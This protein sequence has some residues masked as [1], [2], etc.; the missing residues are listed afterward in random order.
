LKNTT[1]KIGRQYLDTP[2]AFTEKWNV[3][4]NSFD[5]IVVEN[6]DIRNVTLVGTYIGKG[7]GAF[8]RVTNGERFSDYGL[9]GG[10]YA[11][12]ALTNFG[13][14]VNVWYYNVKSD[15]NP[16][17]DSYK[18]GLKAWWIDTNYKTVVD[19]V[20][21]NFGA[22]YGNIDPNA[23]NV[24]DTKG[25]AVKIGATFGDFTL[26][27]AYSKMND[28]GLVGLAN[29]A[30]ITEYGANGANGAGGKKTK[31]Y[32]AGIYTDGTAVAMPGSE[33]Y[34]IAGSMKTSIGKFALAY[35][36]CDNDSATKQN[37]RNANTNVDEIDFVYATKVLGIN[38]K[39]IYI[40]RDV[41]TKYDVTTNTNVANSQNVG[42]VLKHDTKH[43]R[44]VLS[45]KF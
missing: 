21:Y 41:D 34:K 18:R 27:G 30:T 33:A 45:K 37:L 9:G 23:D 31:L 6:K 20:K 36:S 14:P 43:V 38:T 11:I 15:D 2:L 42:A 7:N 3:A 26:S 29:T 39:L 24:K 25:G 16:G 4:P 10:A 35:V 8:A 28:D 19:S 44:I 17:T 40:D 5:A 12:G 1:F 32:T 13:I 22:Q